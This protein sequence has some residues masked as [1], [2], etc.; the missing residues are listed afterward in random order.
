M[1]ALTVQKLGNNDQQL[2]LLIKYPTNEFIL[3]PTTIS[4]YLKPIIII[5]LVTLN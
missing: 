1:D 3:A 4:D 5:I 2:Q